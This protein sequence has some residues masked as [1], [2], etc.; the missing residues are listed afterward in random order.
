MA[1]SMQTPIPSYGNFGQTISNS[2]NQAAGRVHDAKMQ[3]ERI[4]SAQTM[5]DKNL[6]HNSKIHNIDS[7]IKIGVASGNFSGLGLENDMGNDWLNQA[8]ANIQSNPNATENYNNL[9]VNDQKIE[10]GPTMAGTTQQRGI[11]KE[12]ETRKVF[13]AYSGVVNEKKNREA[14]RNKFARDTVADMGFWDRMLLGTMH[15]IGNPLTGW[16]D[17]V[18]A[19]EQYYR[20][21]WEDD[22]ER[23]DSEILEDEYDERGL[24]SE[25]MKFPETALSNTNLQNNVIDP[26]APSEVMKMIQSMNQGYGDNT[27]DPMNLIDLINR[28]GR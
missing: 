13:N 20:Q 5:Q 14:D 19:S 24:D 7:K 26:T 8:N 12:D 6:A 15:N 27:V 16:N 25:N 9:S 17:D 18:W 1:V 21:M 23:T 28:Q 22:I 3:Q 10:L 2:V 4:N 11:E